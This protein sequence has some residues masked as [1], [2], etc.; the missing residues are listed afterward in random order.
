MSTWRADR[1]AL[2]TLLRNLLENAIQHGLEPNRQ[3]GE[4]TLK[5]TVV[6]EHLAITVHD[7][8]RGLRAAKAAQVLPEPRALRQRIRHD[9]QHAADPSYQPQRHPLLQIVSSRRSAS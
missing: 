6:G 7:T 8:G 1:G 3:G 5:A 2:F 4:L 9:V